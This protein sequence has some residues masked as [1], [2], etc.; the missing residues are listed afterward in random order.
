MHAVIKDEVEARK[1]FNLTND[2]IAAPL[3]INF[4]DTIPGPGNYICNDTKP[5]FYAFFCNL[6]STDL[7]WYYNG[8]VVSTFHASDAVGTTYKRTFPE[9]PEKPVHNITTT[10]TELNVTASEKF[11]ISA[12]FCSSTL[13]I[14]PFDDDDFEVIPF[15]VFCLTHCSD[16]NYT[17]ICQSQHYEVAGVCIIIMIIIC[18]ND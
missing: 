2:D 11:N 18:S 7:I 8:R 5:Y 4:A 6:Y 1:C 14:Q 17:A 3:P 13:T 12:S 16:E 15:N 9:P 10:L